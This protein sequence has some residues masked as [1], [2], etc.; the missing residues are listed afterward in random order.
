MKSRPGSTG[1]SNGRG[2]RRWGRQIALAATVAVMAAFLP[3]VEGIVEAQAAP[4]TCATHQDAGGNPGCEVTIDAQDFHTGNSLANFNFIVNDDNTKLPSDPLSLSTESNSPIMAE[5]GCSTLACNGP[6]DRKTVTLP[7]GRYLVSVRSLDHK[8]WGAYFT[9]PDDAANNGMLTEHIRLTTQSDAHPLPLAKIRVFVFNDN[10]WTN[11]APDTEENGLGGFRVGLEEQTGSAVTVDYNNNPL[12]GGLCRT[13]SNP[14]DLGFVEIPNLGPASYFIDVHPPAGPC[15]SDPNSQWFQTTT[16]DGGLNLW[17]PTEEG[18]DGTG[19]PGEQLWEP[20]NIRTAYWFGFVCG[21]QPFAG[22]RSGEI[23]GQARNWVEWAPY[24]TG[25]FND[26]VDYPLVALSDASSDQTVFVGRGDANGNFDI[27]DVPNG[28]YNLAIWDEQLSYIMRFKPVSVRNGAV[29]DVNETGDD[30]SIGVGVSRWFGWLDG[31]VYKDLN[32][33]GQYDPPG[34]AL[35]LCDA[36][37]ANTDV[38]QRWR[39]GS[40]KEGTMTDPNGYYSYPTAEGGALGR[41]IIGEQGFGR[42]SADPGAST[43]DERTGAVTPSCLVNGTPVDPCV[44]NSLGGGLLMNNLLLEGHRTTVDW[45]KHDYAPGTPGQ[46]VGITYFATTRNEFYADKQAHENYEPAIPD[47][48]V[49]LETPGP[50]GLPNTNDDVIVNNYITDH[51]Y[52]PSMEPDP[53][54]VQNCGT[55]PRD[56]SGNPITDLNPNISPN[57]LEVPLT[58]AQTKDGAFDGGYAFADYCPNGYDIGAD[59]GTCLGGGD[60]VPLVAGDYIVHAIMPKDTNDSRACNPDPLNKRVSDPHGTIPGGGNGCLYRIVREEDVNVDLG[61]KFTPAI[62]PPPCNGDDHIIDQ[63]T[64]VDRST[65]FGVAGAHAPLCDK[66]LVELK[67]GQNANA[68]FFMMTNFPTDPN[69][70]N[71]NDGQTGDVAE[72]GRVVGQVFNDIYFERDKLSPW[73][74]E[75]R[76]IANIPVGVYARV[77]TVP[78]T[79]GTA[80]GVRATTEPPVLQSGH[81]ALDQDDQDDGRRRLRD[82]AA[83]DRDVQLPHSAGPCPGMYLLTVND[84]GTKANP[85]PNYNPNI[86]TATSVADVWPGQTTQMDTPL[87]PISGTACEDPAGGTTPD[88]S[89]PAVPELLQ[90]DKAAIPAGATGAGRQ[91]TILGDFISSP[92]NA[93]GTVR[94]TDLATGVVTDLTTGNGGVV[95][96][97]PGTNPPNTQGTPDTIVIQVPPTGPGFGPG[98]KQMTLISAASNGSASSVNGLTLHVLGAAVNPRTDTATTFDNHYVADPNVVAAD[99]GR[100]VTSSGGG[101]PAGTTITALAPGGFLMSNGATASG[102]RTLTI[103]KIDT[104]VSVTNGSHTANDP[105]IVAG[106]LNRAVSITG[107]GPDYNGRTITSV[108]TA[109]N[110]HSFVFSGGAATSTNSGKTATITKT[111]AGATIN[112]GFVVLD[113][114]ATAGDLGAPVSGPGIPPGTTITS[115]SPG[116]SF[117]MSNPATG[118]GTVSISVGVAYSA[119]LRTLVN[120]PAPTLNGTQ[121]QDAIDAASP[122]SI[123]LLA[124]GTYNENVL[125]WKPLTLQGRGPGG[126]VGAHEL[127][128]RDPEDP[129]FNIPGTVIDGRYFQQNA[130]V[131]DA[132]VAAHAPYVLPNF[133]PR[134]GPV[135]PSGPS[136]VLRGADITVVAQQALPDAY[137]PS[138]VGAVNLLAATTSRIDGLGLMTGQGEGAGGVQLQ[139]NINNMQITNN[140]LENNS[141]VIAGAIAVGQPYVHASN[142][143]NV[144]INHDRVIGNG[145]LTS[146]GGIGV[147]YDSNGYEVANSV[148]CSNFGVEYGGGMSHIGLSPNGSIHDNRIYYNEAVDSGGGIALEGELP[149]GST[150]LSI[151]TGAVNVDRNLIQS[152]ASI[153]DDGGGMFVMDS[154][155]APINIRNNMVVNNLAADTG[156]LTL[157]DASR[158]A[159]INNTIANNNSTA[160]SENSALNVPHSAGLASEANDTLWQN[161]AA[162]AAQYPNAGTR[163][164]FSNPVAL[165]NNIFWNNNAFTLDQFGPGAALVPQGVIDLEVRGTSSSADTF[166]PR[167]SDLTNGLS[168]RSNGARLAVPGNQGNL[169][170]TDPLFVASFINELTVSGAR[171]DPQAAAVSITGQDPP[172]GLTG[173]YHLTA[174]SPVIDRGVGFSNINVNVPQNQTPTA[175]S[176]LAPCSGTISTTGAFL[177]GDFDGQFRPQLIVNARGRRPW[178]LGA[179][180]VPATGTGTIR[181]FQ[182]PGSYD[183]PGNGTTNAATFNWNGVGQLQCSGSTVLRIP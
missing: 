110:P 37:I 143:H 117:T 9:L 66:H 28:D 173:D 49:L 82:P 12:C 149:V 111:D 67:N 23:T 40:I 133:A 7:D 150:T 76:P 11:G 126:I 159:I 139:A 124:P 38:D 41:W 44:P 135:S 22:T 128:A 177:P 47:V 121:L 181:I 109:T 33:N 151:G 80:R 59:N 2:L 115:V 72:P 88:P 175:A 34:C 94:L 123:L 31:H 85:N 1:P 39:D 15:N 21:P 136:V 36:P 98:P 164:R 134:P 74:G 180:E 103:T 178:D 75:P 48:Q 62:P 14:A 166:T 174:G 8:M 104:G 5:G 120:V 113:T 105:S 165:F 108:N 29:V 131:F 162:Y 119:Y 122:G 83:L 69:G 55:F 147:F 158:V 176:I 129:R 112:S 81:L 152:N 68:D 27:T 16:I 78:E 90:V 161:S 182:I 18:A 77:D 125:L 170:G 86:L 160:S 60:P 71:P 52:Q 50:D 163:P 57:C 53:G 58:G 102:T 73:Y 141:G 144:R 42:F 142:N 132:R 183:P 130:T 107:P 168:L 56:F 140:V 138:T 145:G 157:D 99:V 19:A 118:A 32:G 96:W 179:D 87:D 89:D 4:A 24:T 26:P 127:Q 156:N 137:G 13:S 84:P 153:M 43:H 65:Y 20:P 46:I 30:G 70:T 155:D 10:T 45:G 92:N 17:A 93:P 61:N 25:T 51:W 116:V 97:T 106:D 169:I 79:M 100:T 167:F 171:L 101:I 64:L 6:E 154:L 35:S 114:S 3:A 63:A 172:V 54:D 148:L 91:V 146:S 95:S